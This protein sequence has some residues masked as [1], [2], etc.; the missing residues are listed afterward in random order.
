[1]DSRNPSLC[2]ECFEASSPE[3]KTFSAACREAHC[4]YCD[5]QPCAGGTDF[6]ALATGVPK[7]KFMCMPC[8]IEH[9]RYVQDQLA[10]ASPDL[11]HN[12]QLD[13]L[14]KLDKEADAHMKQWV[15][16]KR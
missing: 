5:A 11:S 9:N 14:R 10:N 3:I 13:L 6:L 1:M 12:E 8:S 4:E 2:E 16:D 7:L 15:S